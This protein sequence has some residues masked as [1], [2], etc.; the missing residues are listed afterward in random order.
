MQYVNIR[1]NVEIG[2][3]PLAFKCRLDQV[4][5]GLVQLLTVDFVVNKIIVVITNYAMVGLAKIKKKPFKKQQFE[6]AKKMVN[7]LYF[8]GL[9]F[10]SIPFS[11]LFTIIILMFHFLSF[12]FEKV[13]LFKFGT[14]PKKEWKAQDAGG[15]FIKFYLIT[16]IVTGLTS[17]LLFLSSKTFAKEYDILADTLVTCDEDEPTATCT[18]YNVTEIKKESNFMCGPFIKVESAWDMVQDDVTEAS[19]ITQLMYQVTVNVLIV[20]LICLFFYLKFA[21]TESSLGV[22]QDTMSER[23]NAFESANAASEAKL[24]K[25]N[26]QVKNLEM[27]VQAM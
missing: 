19:L 5:A 14:K 24:R 15:F 7:L 22:A 9:V 10:L 20:W 27:Q 2:F 11:P 13:V 12:K 1:N 25:L 8:Q 4:A 17:V 3:Q 23:N 26:K 21:F 6:V 18:T 16:I